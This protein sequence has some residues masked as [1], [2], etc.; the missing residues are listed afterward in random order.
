MLL[1]A[2]S[3][4][5]PIA[6]ITLGTADGETSLAAKFL[7]LGFSQDVDLWRIGTAIDSLVCVQATC[8][9]VGHAA[10]RYTFIAIA[11]RG[12]LGWRRVGWLGLLGISRFHCTSNGSGQITC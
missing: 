12:L 11:L 9:L 5:Q 8:S 10:R 6:Q 1:A 3:V 7:E 4:S 2:I